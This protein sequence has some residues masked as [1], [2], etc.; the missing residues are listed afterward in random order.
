M[1]FVFG[2]SEFKIR[3]GY[4][5]VPTPDPSLRPG[6]GGLGTTSEWFNKLLFCIDKS[7]HP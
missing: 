3:M 7:I 6:R 2:I 4:L 1:N 5:V